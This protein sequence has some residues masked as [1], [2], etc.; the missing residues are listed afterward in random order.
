MGYSIPLNT[1]EF[2]EDVSSAVEACGE[3]TAAAETDAEISN[4]TAS[5]AATQNLLQSLEENELFERPELG[6]VRA[7]DTP[8][9][10]VEP[11]NFNIS[12]KLRPPVTDDEALGYDATDG[13]GTN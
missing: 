6:V 11:Y 4:L 3:D 13:G 10:P 1:G 2:G 12:V 9:N 8:G 5:I 7:V